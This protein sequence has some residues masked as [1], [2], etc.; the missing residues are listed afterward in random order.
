MLGGWSYAKDRNLLS[1]TLDADK[2]TQAGE[3]VQ[4]CQ[5]I[6]TGYTT[7]QAPYDYS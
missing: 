7:G 5:L 6:V 1:T 3:E 4:G 2:R